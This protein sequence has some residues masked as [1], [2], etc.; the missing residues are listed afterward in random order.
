MLLSWNSLEFSRNKVKRISFFHIYNLRQNQSIWIYS[1]D[2]YSC[3]DNFKL[4][5]TSA[6]MVKIPNVNVMKIN[7]FDLSEN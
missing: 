5:Y 2:S 1:F 3:F 7:Y 4:F 6:A